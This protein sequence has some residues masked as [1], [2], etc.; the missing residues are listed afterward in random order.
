MRC[1]WQV[2]SPNRWQLSLGLFVYALLTAPAADKIRVYHVPKER[3]RVAP[4]ETGHAQLLGQNPHSTAAQPRVSY[5]APEGWQDDGPGE[6]RVAGFTIK[7][8]GDQTAQVAIT[9][10][11]G[12]AGR[13]ALIV[14]MWRQQ[15][16]MPELGEAEATEQLRT[17]EVGDE[18]G[19][20]FEINGT[21]TGGTAMRIVT[22]MLHRGATSWFFKLQGSSPLVEAE[23]PKF[24]KFLQSVKIE[25][26]SSPELPAGHPPLVDD[27]G[28][29]ASPAARARR[30]GPT[31]TVP[32]GWREIDGGQ[33][34]FAKFVIAD[35]AGNQAA[36]NVSTSAG[37]GGGLIANVNR[38]RGQ[39]GLP[40]WSAAEVEQ[41]AQKIATDA[42]PATL[43]EMRGADAQPPK[44]TLTIAAVVPQNHAT[45][46]YKLMGDEKVVLAQ[47]EAFL[48]F[49]KGVQY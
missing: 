37:D 16:G 46:F 41:Q 8:E 29:G 44:P 45:W 13:E 19:K 39:L 9:P 2:V 48:T 23:T 22:V 40:A 20:L 49:V 34:L 28:T 24:L 1:N 14:N 26:A 31:W 6:M 36:V 12:M 11:P 32:G 7:G 21:S 15:V 17:V 42:G 33:F 47:K 10:L 4:V 18:A 38:W 25:A 3:P 5:L 30:D 35:P 43:I 27:R